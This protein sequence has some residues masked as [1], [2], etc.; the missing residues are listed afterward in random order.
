MGIWVGDLIRNRIEENGEVKVLEIGGGYGALAYWFKSAFPNA[1]YTIIDLPESLLFSR[2]YLSLTRPDIK[3]SSE[4]NDIKY[5]VR[6]LS[7]YM[8]EEL[9][10]SFHLLSIH[11][12]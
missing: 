7:N 1:T 9:D 6:F 2:L 5:G 8:A 10:D 12:Q 11:F 4:L 3:T